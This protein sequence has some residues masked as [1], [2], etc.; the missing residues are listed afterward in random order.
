MNKLWDINSGLIS[1][2][3]S[4]KG[5]LI[6]YEVFVEDTIQIKG[7]YEGSVIKN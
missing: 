1:I 7:T 2:S 6:T 4:P 5:Y 3:E